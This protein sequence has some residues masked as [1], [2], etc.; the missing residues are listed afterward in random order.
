MLSG[1]IVLPAAPPADIARET[2]VR[3]DTS[4][5]T[6]R[7]IDSA[8]LERYL[9]DADFVYDQQTTYGLSIWEQ[10]KLWIRYKILKTIFSR[11]NRPY[12]ETLTYLFILVIFIFTIYRLRDSDFIGAFYSPADR[13]MLDVAAHQENIH[14][15]NF[16]Q[17]IETAV[18][19]GQLRKAVRLHYLATLKKLSDHRLINWQAGKANRDYLQELTDGDLQAEFRALTRLFDYVWYGDFPV[20]GRQY[21]AVNEHFREFNTRIS[22]R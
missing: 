14:E 3:Y 20:D 7:H 18:A 9:A 16:P 19:Q 1:G 21:A 15:I 5:I 10:I 4:A 17:A 2:T 6:V 8:S 13:S 22:Q 12:R 11:E